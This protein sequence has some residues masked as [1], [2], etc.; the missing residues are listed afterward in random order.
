MSLAETH[1][2]TLHSVPFEHVA[3]FRVG[4][5]DPNDPKNSGTR[6]L[7]T[8]FNRGRESLHVGAKGLLELNQIGRQGYWGLFDF[9]FHNEYGET[10]SEFK[11]KR[12]LEL[13]EISF[14]SWNGRKISLPVIDDQFGD[15]VVAVHTRFSASEDPVRIQIGE[16]SIV[17][18]GIHP[19]IG[20]QQITYIDEKGRYRNAS[21]S[22]FQL[23]FDQSQ[24]GSERMVDVPVEVLKVLNKMN[25]IY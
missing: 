14:R 8:V 23:V 5:P 10:F 3:E 17:R 2:E 11:G 15:V 12:G 1:G 19:L 6:F 16:R 4:Y 20:T 7:D 24:K 22:S 9:Y 13:L 25:G 18:P 21:G